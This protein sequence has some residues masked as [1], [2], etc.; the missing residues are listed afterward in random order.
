MLADAL[1][2]IGDPRG[3]FIALQFNPAQDWERREM[4]LLQRNG[5]T[6]LG[7]LRGA[8]TPIAYEKGFLASCILYDGARV[9]GCDEWATVHTVELASANDIEPLLH[10]VMRSLRHVASIEIENVERLRSATIETLAVIGEWA[11]LPKL[12]RSLG[13]LPALRRL[14]LRDPDRLVLERGKDGLLSSLTAYYQPALVDVLQRIPS[15]A[16]T[17]LVAEQVPD[18]EVAALRDAASRQTRLVDVR[19][20]PRL[21]D[22]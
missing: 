9:V 13:H 10:P 12:Y 2:A 17:A 7:E 4:R 20:E 21:Y 15:D 14:K 6:W 5:L 22:H 16:L 8:V 1:Q 19:I 11:E 3:E 18:H